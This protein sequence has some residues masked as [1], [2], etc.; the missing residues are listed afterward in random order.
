M[1]QGAQPRATLA[2]TGVWKAYPGVQAVQ[3]ADFVCV[4]G[5]IHALVGE[6]GAGKSTLVGMASGNVRADRGAVV[7]GEAQLTKAT[8]ALARRL[9]LEV[10]YQDDALVPDLSVAENLRLAVPDER[11]PTFRGRNDWAAAELA[12]FD[13]PIDPRKPVRELSVSARQIVEIVRA[14]ASAPLALVLD[15]PTSAL[16]QDEVQHLHALLRQ[17]A[18][19]GVAVAYITHRLRE[20]FAL[21]D[22]VSVMRDGRMVRERVPVSSI[23]EQELVTQMVGRAVT[24]FFPERAVSTGDSRKALLVAEQ[25]EGAVLRGASLTVCEGEVVGL[26][27]VEGNGQREFLRALAGIDPQNGTLA[28]AGG[29]LDGE[30]VR[31]AR[32]KGIVYVSGDRRR[33]SLFPTLG[34]REN[35]TVGGLR[36]LFPSGLVT[37]RSERR[38]VLPKVSALQVRARGLEQNV[39]LLSGGN[40]QK[41]A[42]GRAFLAAPRV[43]LVDEPT[44]GVDAGARAEIYAILRDAANHGSAVVVRSSDAVELAGLCDRV[45]VFV[46]GRV[47]TILEGDALTEDA[48][49][50]AAVTHQDDAPT[51]R[52][53]EPSA[54]P[55]LGAGVL[56][57]ARRSDFAPVVLLL[58]SIIALGAFSGSKYDFFLSSDNVANMLFLAVPL[59]F[60]ALGQATV[61]LIGGIDLSIGPVIAL[62]TVAVAQLMGEHGGARGVGAI[63]AALGIGVAVGLLNAFLVR[64]VHILP[65]IATLATYFLVQGIAL[66]WLPI[67]GGFISERA[68]DVASDRLWMIPW[69]FVALLAVALALELV[70]RRGISGASYRAVGSRP[71]AASRLGVRVELVQYSAYALAGLLGAMGGVFFAMTIGIG[72]PALG[73]TFTLASISAVV[74][75]GLS[76]WGGRGS[77]LGPVVAAVLLAV[78]GSASSFANLPPHIQLYV[79]GGLLLFAIALYS[80]IRASRTARDETITR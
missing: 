9:G 15:E 25:L 64:R 71:V 60:A 23:S 6:N 4:G 43:Y 17:V 53:S 74:L 14:L 75:G 26:A 78:I 70:Y 33:E 8:P 35:M 77:F 52:A 56:Q 62:T 66:L 47:A 42:L 37:A 50:A 55:R 34:V 58:L 79:Q 5:E 49:V 41:V 21:A 1:T 3:G 46:R 18:D 63:I 68:I 10:V 59:G 7:I 44:Q 80:R 24:A 40:Q 48:I 11:R 65:L 76:T 57:W 22:V 54:R 31:E 61:M 51:K 27:G 39:M 2:L 36:A 19:E 38:F 16:A 20:V 13:N 73:V 45:A 28:I 72:D 12:R 67:P 29:A 30:S 69:A 32:R